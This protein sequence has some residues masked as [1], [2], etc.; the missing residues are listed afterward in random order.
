MEKVNNVI[1]G[2]VQD[3]ISAPTYWLSIFTDKQ[4]I[5]LRA[6][7]HTVA[8]L[9]SPLANRIASAQELEEIATS[10]RTMSVEEILASKYVIISFSFDNIGKIELIERP[11]SFFRSIIKFPYADKIIKLSMSK[12]T[13]R[14]IKSS[15]HILN[16][17]LTSEVTS[18]HSKNYSKNI[19]YSIRVIGLIIFF[20][21]VIGLF[22]KVGIKE[23]LLVVAGLFIFL[24]RKIG[25]YV[26]AATIGIDFLL[27]RL[28]ASNIDIEI[29]L[30]NIIATVILAGILV[31]L[32]KFKE[33]LK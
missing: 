10:I 29:L 31:F 24:K 16:P 1:T 22:D 13:I 17:N 4:V 8:E 32:W 18:L 9:V 6:S 28:L 21:S 15:L 19:S 3:G 25:L 11:A 14:L 33:E 23:I 30:K 26:L 5:F 20:W 2:L 12:D 27:M 7:N